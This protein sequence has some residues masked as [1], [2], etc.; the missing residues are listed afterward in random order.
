MSRL[1]A[2]FLHGSAAALSVAWAALGGAV[3]LAFIPLAEGWISPAV[4]IGLG[5]Y[6]A[7]IVAY[8]NLNKE[9][10]RLRS[11]VAS[12]HDARPRMHFEKLG[13]PTNITLPSKYVIE[14]WQLWFVNRPAIRSPDAVARQLTAMVEFCDST[15]QKAIEPFIGQWAITRM[16]DHVGWDELRSQIDLGPAPSRGK[17]MLICQTSSYL[18]V[19]SRETND[20]QITTRDVYVLAGENIHAYPQDA[21][22][23]KYQLKP[24]VVRVRVTLTADNMEEQESQFKITRQQDGT[25][26]AI[27]EIKL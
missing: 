5:L 7:L 14:V 22:H 26:V 16:P 18:T 25:V 21:S 27:T 3:G 20:E 23:P 19:R 24:D 10:E 13:G 12:G 4:G 9:F 8:N 17:L 6:V 2:I 1:F 15:W 11:D